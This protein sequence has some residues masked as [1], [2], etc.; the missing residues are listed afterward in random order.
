MKNIIGHSVY[1]LI[2]ILV[3]SFDEESGNTFF[4]EELCPVVRQSLEDL[5]QELEELDDDLNVDIEEFFEFFTV[6]LIVINSFGININSYKAVKQ[7]LT[8][9][10]NNSEDR[11]I[12]LLI[13]GELCPD[14]I[15]K[16]IYS[17]S[18]TRISGQSTA[19]RLTK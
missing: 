17:K 6:D 14:F 8:Q 11:N 2:V 5:I 1:Q 9:L 19:N 4:T 12:V 3:L 13:S 15:H 7:Y 10:S 18:K 16:T